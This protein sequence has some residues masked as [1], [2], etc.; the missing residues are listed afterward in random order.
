[1]RAS[2][3]VLLLGGTAEA[4]AM[5]AR[6]TDRGLP[7]TTS[8]AGRTREPAPVKGNIRTGGFGGVEGLAEYLRRNDIALLIDMT[9][10][11]ATRIS[12]NARA[13]ASLSGVPLLAWQRPGWEKMDGDAWIGVPDISAA[14]A[15]IPANARALLALGSQH[16]APFAA[17]ADVHFLVRM[18]DP[19][20]VPLALP[21]HELLMAKPGNVEEEY[22]LLKDSQMTHIVCRNSGGKASYAKIAA[23]RLLALPV[24]MITRAGN[25][26]K[27]QSLEAFEEQIVEAIAAR[28][29]HL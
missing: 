3:G 12:A 13:A 6:L 23:A 7:V 25:T 2:K 22:K 21:S 24:I 4:A 9:H 20:L 19:P 27:F 29:Q 8:L 28:T 1:L 18:I 14:V 5:A 17:R 16:I 15:A 26:S 11:F 10:P